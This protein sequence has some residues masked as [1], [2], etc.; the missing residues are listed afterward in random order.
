MADEEGV[1]T[2]Y[3]FG[4]FQLDSGN[5]SLRKY[6]EKVHLSL[7]PLRV[8]LALVERARTV[9]SA[10]DLLL[11]VWG[12]KPNIKERNN[13]TQQIHALRKKLG[14][15]PGA[16]QYIETVPG[17]GYRFVAQVEIVPTTKRGPSVAHAGEIAGEHA[18]A[19]I[20]DSIVVFCE[21]DAH[22]V[23]GLGTV[24]RVGDTIMLDTVDEAGHSCPSTGRVVRACTSSKD[25][26]VTDDAGYV[27]GIIKLDVRGNF[28]VEADAMADPDTMVKVTVV[29][30][31]GKI[32]GAP[33]VGGTGK[34]LR[35]PVLP[36]TH[37]AV[38][39]PK[40]LMK[41]T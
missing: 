20:G 33:V 2:I 26:L 7:R 19:E 37:R 27:I 30:G 11:L 22:L 23:D 12:H 29:G 34:A 40:D 38:V 21:D 17:D 8:L 14:E 28:F 18:G 15:T 35:V 32:P 25:L 41:K 4:P 39:I 24:I 6:G 5:D 3:K 13:V 10:D 36:A 1:P 31:A 9:V 16:N